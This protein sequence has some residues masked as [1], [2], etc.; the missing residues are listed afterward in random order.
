MNIFILNSGSSTIKAALISPEDGIR[1][2]D[3][4]IDNI[5]NDRCCLI[6]D[7]IRHPLSCK[8]H[9]EALSALMAAAEKAL[10]GYQVDAVG[11]RVVHGGPSFT[12]PTLITD[13]VVQAIS[14][15]APMAPLHIPPSLAALDMARKQWPDIPH[16]AVFDTAF[17]ATLPNRSRHYALPK[18]IVDKLN[19]RRYGFHGTSHRFVA[20][21]A[22]SYLRTDIR[23]LRLIT[24]HLGSGC[25]VTAIEY[26]RSIETSMGMTPLEGLVMS[27]RPGDLDAGIILQLIKDLDGDIEALEDL[28]N[29]KSGFV[30]LTGTG[31][32]RKI[33]ERAAE[34]DRDCQLAINI[35]CHSVRKY[36]GA[37]AAVMGGIDAIVF[38]AGIGENSALIRHRIGQRFDYLGAI[39]D[40]DKNRE[41]IVNKAQPVCDISADISR[42]RLLVIAT[43]EE[44]AIAQQTAQLIEEQAKSPT[45]LH[46]P[47][48][49]SARHIHL[50]Q[51]TIEKLF[52]PGYQLTIRRPLSQPGQYSVEETVT[53]VGPK[54]KIEK[55]RILGPARLQDQ[56]EISRSDEFFLGVDAPVRASGDLDNTPGI[57]LAGPAGEVTLTNGLI[58]ALRHIHMSPDDAAAFKVQDNDVVDVAIGGNGR[59]LTFDDVLI[60]V[61][62]DF[63]LEMHVD[64]D[65][66]N[67]AG[68]SSGDMGVLVS[69]ETHAQMTRRKIT[70]TNSPAQDL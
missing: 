10:V 2:V 33:E 4:R 30:G 16:I 70:A 12:E 60:R 66:A 69:T 35:F 29:K 44:L 42:A 1:H 36:I 46:I 65:E 62:P 45:N 40:E 59:K 53:L 25:S 5:G 9:G 17:H 31:D 20:Q 48:A 63:R 47:V 64:T 56:V 23:N 50:T 27:S 22:A 58:C 21:T 14:D 32:M 37:Y 19:I 52:G 3:M 39:L 68:L 61:H 54:R 43:D 13:H 38:T 6:L 7:T 57:T 8:D 11:H 18:D 28:L 15:L 49:V 41:A 24:C 34:G 55:V 51:G 67:A 26:G